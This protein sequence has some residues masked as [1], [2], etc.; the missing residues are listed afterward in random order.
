MAELFSLQG[1]VYSAVRSAITGKPGTRTWLGNVSACSAALATENSNKNES[2]SGS[3]LL[4]GT[5]QKSKTATLTMTMD[6]WLPENLGIALYGTSAAISGSTVTAEAAPAGLVVGS[7]IQLANQFAS[8]IVVH[9][10]AG[11]PAT[12]VLGTD[13][14]ITSATL[15]L[16]TI[17]S[18]GSYTQPFKVNYTYANASALQ[19]FT[20][21]KPPERWITFDG[22]NTNTGEPVIAELYR[23]QFDPVK[24]FGFI[25][26]DWGGL[27]MSA[28]VLY[29]SVNA[30]NSTFGGFGRL[31]TG[32]APT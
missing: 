9:D 4:Y 24:D 31:L 26:D 27:E 1:K 3:R 29:D 19:M 5:L 18:V 15:G 20:D 6:E 30:S 17:I 28:S 13:Y 21:V 10:S 32:P 22:E 11:S 12:L 7:Q 14:A 25:Q 23:C 8:S 2:F 16:I